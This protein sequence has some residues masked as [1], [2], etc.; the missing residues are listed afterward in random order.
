[1]LI[2]HVLDYRAVESDTLMMT[3]FYKEKVQE[4]DAYLLVLFLVC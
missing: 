1:M 2:G 3:L 4:N